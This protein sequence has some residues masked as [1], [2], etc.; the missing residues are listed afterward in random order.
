MKV[1]IIDYGAGNIFSVKQAFIRIGAEVILSDNETEIRAASHVVFPGVGHAGSAMKQLVEM[2]LDK[3]I[4]ELRQPVL[5]ICLGMQ[6]MCDFTEEGNTNGLG[7][8]PV[9]VRNLAKM[10]IGLFAIWQTGKQHNTPLSYPIPHMGWNDVKTQND[11][12][13]YYFV[14]NYAAE[15]CSETVGITEYPLPFSAILK[16]NNFTGVQFHPEKSGKAGEDLLKQFLAL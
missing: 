8:F 3:V 16:K 12:N 9:Q 10:Q 11:V 7:I 1:V 15:I 2:G 13:S 6:L 4:P 5:G 14:H